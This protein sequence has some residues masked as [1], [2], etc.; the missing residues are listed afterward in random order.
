MLLGNKVAVVTGGGSGIGATICKE[1]AFEGAQV[2]V[3]D[4]NIEAAERVVEEIEE[5]K[6]IAQA[7]KLNVSSKE[8]TKQVAQEIKELYGSIDIWVNNAGVSKITP[9]LEHDEELLD[10]TLDVNLK[11]TFFGSQEA[12]KQMLPK[13]SGVIIN[14]ASQSG[15]VGTS[16]YQAYCASKFGVIGLTQSISVEFANQG[17]RAN[18]ICPGV[19]YTPMWEQQTI[20][21][22]KKRDMNPDKVMDYMRSKIPAG[23]LGEKKD[24]ARTVVFLASDDASYITGQSI[25]LTGGTV[26]H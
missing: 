11:G 25:N 19:V 17:I 16:N 13:K 12:I 2:A 9:F 6:G 4:V 5:H 8:N 14:M 20:D 7:W 1:L 21:Y 24:I 22:G 23:R 26:M 3:T 10:L 18:S 15:K